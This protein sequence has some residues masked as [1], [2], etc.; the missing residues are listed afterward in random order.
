[1][2]CSTLGEAFE[3]VLDRLKAL[4]GAVAGRKLP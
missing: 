4:V 1:M 2:A 3:A